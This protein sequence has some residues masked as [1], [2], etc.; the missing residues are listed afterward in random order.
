M[1]IKSLFLIFVYVTII[2]CDRVFNITNEYPA[3]VR[4]RIFRF[5]IYQDMLV[6]LS[7]LKM[8]VLEGHSVYGVVDRIRNAGLVSR[9]YA[10]TSVVL[11]GVLLFDETTNHHVRL[12]PVPYVPPTIDEDMKELFLL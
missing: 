5:A 2:L 11:H 4:N 10:A 7:I 6:A 9:A 3:V 1:L 8:M 12:T